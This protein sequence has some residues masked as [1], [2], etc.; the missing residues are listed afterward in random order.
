MSDPP[1]PMI[2]LALPGMIMVEAEWLAFEVLTIFSSQFG[3]SYLAA[4]SILGTLTST[5]FQLPFPISIAA[6]TR[7]ANLIGARLVHAARTSACVAVG[8]AAIVSIFNLV[9]LS[10]LR[11]QLPKLLT[12]DEDVIEVVAQIMP[13]VSIMQLFDGM[14]CMAHGLLRGIGRQHFGGYANLAAYYLIALPISFGLGFGLDWKLEGLWT[15]VTLGL[16]L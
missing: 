11:Y 10:S 8:A 13:L 14:A 3:T 5:T 9:L 6:S 12:R 2:R 15:G 4:Q 7:I 16:F 1:G